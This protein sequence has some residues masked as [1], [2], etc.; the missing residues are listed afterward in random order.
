[1]SENND[2]RDPGQEFE[3][4]LQKSINTARNIKNTA[5]QLKKLSEQTKSPPSANKNTTNTKKTSTNS[6]KS[7]SAAKSK[8]AQKAAE[9]GKAAG[10]EAGKAAAQKSGEAAATAGAEGAAASAGGSAA[11]SA[12]AA[13]ATG[14][15]SLVVQ[16]AI[17]AAKIAIDQVKKSL[18]SDSEDGSYNFKGIIGI[19]FIIFLIISAAALHNV[20][21]ASSINYEETQHGNLPDDKRAE[22][23]VRFDTAHKINKDWDGTQ[24]F[25][26]AS[27][28]YIEATE[29]VI[30]RAFYSDVTRIVDGIDST[31]IVRTMIDFVKEIFGVPTHDK[32]KTA[33]Y[34]YNNVYPYAKK[35]DGGYYSVGD[36]LASYGFDGGSNDAFEKGNYTAIPTEDLFND[37]NYSEIFAVITQGSKYSTD[38]IKL[39][40]YINLFL[41]KQSTRSRMLELKL[42]DPI[43]F[44]T[45]EEDDGEDDEGNPKKKTI[46]VETDDPNDDELKKCD[47]VKYYYK[48]TLAPYGLADLYQVANGL[49][50]S[51]DNEWGL[52]DNISECANKAV[53][54]MQQPREHFEKFKNNVDFLDYTEKYDRT[55]NRMDKNGD[56]NIS[57]DENYLGPAYNEDRNSHSPRL[58]TSEFHGHP[59]TPGKPNRTTTGRSSWYYIDI[60]DMIDIRD[61]IKTVSEGTDD[62]G[63]IEMPDI[64]VP[65][66][67]TS[68]QI[69]Q[70][71]LEAG[72]SADKAAAMALAYHVIEPL[73]GS[74]FAVGVM[75]NVQE[76]GNNG[77][78]EYENTKAYWRKASPEVKAIAGT[79]LRQNGPEKVQTLL[80]GI[81]AGTEGIGV[82]MIQWSGGRR[83]QLLNLYNSSGL[84]SDGDFSLSDCMQIE[85]SMMVAEFKGSYSF[86][87][88]TSA[89]KSPA[90]CARNVCL[91]YEIPAHKFAAANTRAQ[92]ARDIVRAIQNA[93]DYKGDQENN[94]D[95]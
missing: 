21:S 4:D 37:V 95:W 42:S 30:E 89:G 67:I 91:N 32:S 53:E 88:S 23:N 64:E 12:G 58:R 75:A 39:D 85:I 71:L 16:A 77:Q 29:T 81:P 6:P 36:F 61:L 24:P 40:D 25:H 72:Y 79:T 94:I 38:I 1:M 60:D 20:P 83:V 63:D 28:V 50:D 35:R 62:G 87:P 90:E 92:N 68:L 48:I 93:D 74:N 56:G 78:I 9:Q 45:Y 84:G 86:V 34:L 8:S 65:E 57:E 2:G 51:T 19:I 5:E 44:G 82:G 22:N 3:D 15:I 49:C 26:Q 7:D 13:A 70:A 46:K 11:A 47:E 69:Y 18:E 27:D 41:S 54:I 66:D 10:K 31:D 17:L 33:K 73:Y 55:L 52:G 80:T 76:E 43:F 14:G 59:A